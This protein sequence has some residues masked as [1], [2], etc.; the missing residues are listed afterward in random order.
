[1]RQRARS[2]VAALLSRLHLSGD[3]VGL[4]PLAS[5][6]AHTVMPPPREVLV[7]DA[8]GAQQ[9]RHTTGQLASST[10]L[11]PPCGIT[12]RRMAHAPRW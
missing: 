1:L 10:V 4:A 9:Q 8:D 6:R 2:K 5:S 11:L 7:V 12:S 3:G